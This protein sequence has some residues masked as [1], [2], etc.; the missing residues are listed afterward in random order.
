MQTEGAIRIFKRP[1]KKCGVR[2]LKYYGDG[3]SK[4]FEKVE[5]IYPGETVRKYECIGHYQ[6]RVGNRLRKLRTP[7]KGLGGKT[8]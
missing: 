2:Y 5:H 3:D 4:S 7:I 1:V 6:K 8:S